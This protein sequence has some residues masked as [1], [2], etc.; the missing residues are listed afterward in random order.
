MPM[1]GPVSMPEAAQAREDAKKG[2][3][4]AAAIPYDWAI[5]IE[6]GGRG[7]V[8]SGGGRVTVGSGQPGQPDLAPDASA[9]STVGSSGGLSKP[10]MP[11]V[12]RR[13]G[14]SPGP[15]VLACLDHCVNELMKSFAADS[16][17]S[18]RGLTS[19][20][21]GWRHLVCAFILSHPPSLLRKGGG[22]V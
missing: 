11:D 4:Q 5:S 3:G 21:F 13:L 22:V 16:A 12:A 17:L 7:I 10:G 19:C 15:G 6:D 20:Y 9:A 2:D 14:G 1:P 8:E 18:I